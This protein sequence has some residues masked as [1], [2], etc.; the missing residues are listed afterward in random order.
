MRRQNQPFYLPSVNPVTIGLFCLY[1]RS[2][3]MER[4]TDYDRR[5]SA[6]IAYLIVGGPAIHCV[7]KQ[8]YI[9]GTTS[10]GSR[11]AST[12]R[13]DLHPAGTYRVCMAIVRA[14]GDDDEDGQT[15][16]AGCYCQGG[17]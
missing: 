14:D 16:H 13:S 10:V 6:L 2:E 4:T 5:T 3:V 9:P 15:H 12:L 11:P 17:C 8:V 1:S 7:V